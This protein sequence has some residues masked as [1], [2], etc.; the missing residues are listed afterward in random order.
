MKKTSKLFL[1]A[2]AAVAL[3][4]CNSGENKLVQTIDRDMLTVAVE[5]GQ[6][7]Y[8]KNKAIYKFDLYNDKDASFTLSSVSFPTSSSLNNISFTDLRFGVFQGSVG[9]G[10]TTGTG[11][12]FSLQPISTCPA[13]T[14][15]T[16][17]DF[18]VYLGG[19]G[20]A[21]ASYAIT[22]D[23][24]VYITGF[25]V[26]QAYF[27]KTKVTS[28]S[29]A[30]AEFTTFSPQTNQVRIDINADKRTADVIIF[31]AKFENGMAAK[32]IMYQNIPVEIGVNRLTLH[33][34]SPITPHVYASN[35][36]GDPL[37]E[38]TVSS[39]YVALNVCYSAQGVLQMKMGDKLINVDL[40]EFMPSS[41]LDKQS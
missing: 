16:I 3:A 9:D 1:G 24:N 25:A 34:Q 22:L 15:R 32:S 39:L 40:L 6:V 31:Q 10:T 36:A 26:Q 37:P 5:N 38:Y 17:T 30:S 28:L 41:V 19:Y 2:F 35:Q 7:T 14:D 4:S 20:Y 18:N 29:N 12:K 27:S 11:Y 13:L 23:N 33:A 8:T 21:N